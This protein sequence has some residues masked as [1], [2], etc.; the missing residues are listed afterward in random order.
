MATANV[1]DLLA[2]IPE[3]NGKPEELNIFIQHIDEIRSHAMETLFDLRIRTKIVGRANIS[4][5]NNR[6]PVKWEEIKIVLRSNFNISE[7]SESIVNKIKTSEFKNSIDDFYECMLRLLT[8]LNLKNSINREEEWYSC[9]NNE[10]MVLKIFVSKL[11]SEPKLVLNARNPISHLE[12]KEILIETE[13]FYKSFNPRNSYLVNTRT[14][15]FNNP[16]GNN[17][18]FINKNQDDGFHRNQSRESFD[19]NTGFRHIDSRNVNDEMKTA[20]LRGVLEVLG[21]VTVMGRFP[22]KWIIFKP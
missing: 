22:W 3:Y 10:K 16:E 21:H 9:S 15:K 12:A 7:S 11:L 5:I 6:S 2:S 19:G 18:R 14:N 4:M 8:K 20:T 1:F 13:Y 17:K